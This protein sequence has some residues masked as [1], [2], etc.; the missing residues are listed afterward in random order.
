MKVGINSAIVFN[1]FFMEISKSENGKNSYAI[2][3]FDDSNFPIQIY[4]IDGKNAGEKVKDIA[5]S[6]GKCHS[7][8]FYYEK[9]VSK[10]FL[11]CGFCNVIKIYDF[12]LNLWTKEIPGIGNVEYPK[13]I[14]AKQENP[15]LVGNAKITK[16][17]VF[18]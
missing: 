6:K 18:I 11:V 13:I 16:K 17:I 8:A 1:D 2:L 9:I 4:K 14:H 5:K 7:F 10:C 12:T 15:L 3:S